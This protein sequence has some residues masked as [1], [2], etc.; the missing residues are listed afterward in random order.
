[1]LCLGLEG[2]IRIGPE[3]GPQHHACCIAGKHTRA[4]MCL[5]RLVSADVPGSILCHP[6]YVPSPSQVHGTS[7]STLEKGSLVFVNLYK[8][9]D[10][11]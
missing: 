6:A 11:F 1:M 3:D 4:P 7:A 2:G 8:K 10:G 5:Y 9:T